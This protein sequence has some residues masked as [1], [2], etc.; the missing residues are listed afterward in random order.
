MVGLAYAFSASAGRNMS[1][2]RDSSEADRQFMQAVLGKLNA[3]SEK[4]EEMDGNMDADMVGLYI[5]H[6]FV[7]TSEKKYGSGGLAGISVLS[8]S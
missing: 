7:E 4:H 2:E 3:I 6:Y 5:L 8:A 1:T